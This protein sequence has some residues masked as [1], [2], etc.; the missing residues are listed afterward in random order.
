MQIA[1]EMK[2]LLLL[3][4]KLGFVALLLEAVVLSLATTAVLLAKS[5]PSYSG[6]AGDALVLA[7][8][9]NAA[10]LFAFFAV[11]GVALSCCEYLLRRIP[12]EAT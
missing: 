4:R 1:P 5:M 11:L 7:W 3:A 2:P 9:E 10:L 6:P 8:D 12:S